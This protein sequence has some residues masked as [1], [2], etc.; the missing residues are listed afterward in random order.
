MSIRGKVK[1]AYINLKSWIMC[2]GKCANAGRCQRYRLCAGI[3][4]PERAEIAALDE[5][6]T[7]KIDRW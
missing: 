6:G 4:D 1:R 7:C 3:L 5:H 2:A